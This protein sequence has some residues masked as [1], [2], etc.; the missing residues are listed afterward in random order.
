MSLVGFVAVA[1]IIPSEFCESCC[2]FGFFSG[3]KVSVL[4]VNCWFLGIRILGV[5]LRNPIPIIIK[6]ILRLMEDILHQLIW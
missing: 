3:E 2:L 4:M 6:G 5:P 1:H